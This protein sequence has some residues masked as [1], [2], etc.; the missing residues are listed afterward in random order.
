MMMFSFKPSKRS[1]LPRI[2]A[3]VR[4]RV[5]SWKEAAD[6]NESAFNEALVIPRITGLTTGSRFPLARASL[7]T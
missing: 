7:I 6:K 1:I 4:T 3:S 5:V 2:A